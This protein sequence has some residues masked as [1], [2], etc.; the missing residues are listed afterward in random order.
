M[1]KMKNRTLLSIAVTVLLI[2]ACGTQTVSSSPHSTRVIELTQIPAANPTQT[3]ISLGEVKIYRDANAGFALDYSA[4]WFIEDNAAQHAAGSAVYTVSLFSWDRASYTPTPKDL[5]TLP[6]GATKID[7]T[8]FN[9]GPGTLEEAV[10][11]YKNQDS[12]TPVNF[13]KE[14]DWTLNNGEK[15]VY[16]ES[17]GAFGVVATMITLV[18]GRTIYVSGYGNLT[19]VKAIALSLRAE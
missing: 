18:R 12:G 7:I 16:V 3:L 5:N 15:A 1:S 2:T 9:Q 8:V 11:Q 10:N 17:E 13:Q 4:A 14:E 6:D 19:Q